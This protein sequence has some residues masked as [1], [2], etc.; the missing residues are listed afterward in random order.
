MR[1]GIAEIRE[2]AV[3][4]VLG[5]ESAMTGQDIAD[6]VMISGDD[7]AQILWV[8][9]DGKRGRADKIAE[10]DAELAPLGRSAGGSE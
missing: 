2:D 10:Q 9:A 3:A 6:A 7:L 4:H 8:E 5:D 1:L